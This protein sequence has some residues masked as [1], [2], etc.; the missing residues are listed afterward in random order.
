MKVV[1][2]TN[3]ILSSI[4]P[5]SPYKF[6]FD[7]FEAGSYTLSL[8]TEILLEY[9]EKLTANF[10]PFVAELIVGGIV[11]KSNVQFTEVFFNWRL[12]FDDLDDN[13]FVDC[14]LASNADY[15]VTNDRHFSVLKSIPFPSLKVIKIEEFLDLLKNRN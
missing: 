4:S 10:S 9:E 7:Q 15:L 12:I 1:L 8:T 5:Y 14:A 3:I 2:D 6:V 13:K 11:L